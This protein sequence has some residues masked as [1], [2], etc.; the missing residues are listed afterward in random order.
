MTLKNIRVGVV[1][2]TPAL[3]ELDKSVDLVIN[4]IEKAAQEG[5]QLVLFPE[6]FIPCYPRG[7]TFDAI[8][9]R[10]TDK[11][12]N[13]W[14]DYWANSLEVE[15]AQTIRIQE[16]IKKA[17][18]FVALGVTEKEPVGGTLHCAILYFGKDGRFLGKHRKLK[19][20]GLERYIWGESD[21]STLI[22]FDTEVGKIG[23]LICWE[24]YMP[25]ART[26][27]YQQGIEIYL[28]PTADARDSWQSTMQHIALEGRCFVLASNQFVKK[29]DYPDRYQ[30]DLVDEP[31]IMSAGGS[32]I[33]SP[34]GEIL[35]GPLWN[36]EGLLIADLDFSVLAK[37]K[38]DFDCVG[39]YSRNDVF[40]LTVTNQPPIQKI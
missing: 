40:N 2:A 7:L 32:V 33:I 27:L 5:C 4:W 16:A 26:A 6:S 39:H 13:M 30:A 11:G 15:S 25:L 28:A 9:G 17:N 18:L 24:N 23:G 22:S 20:T 34:M 38:L 37:S 31:D 8:V 12:R 35:A 21:G 29:T 3:F 1:Q 10:R 14:L 36:Q 19:P